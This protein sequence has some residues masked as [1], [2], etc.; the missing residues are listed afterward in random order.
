MTEN[1][2]VKFTGVEYNAHWIIN[3]SPSKNMFPSF[4]PSLLLNIQ[5]VQALT[6]H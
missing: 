4:S 1:E 6:S 3:P 2:W 5:T